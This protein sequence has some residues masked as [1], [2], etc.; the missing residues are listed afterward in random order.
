MDIFNEQALPNNTDNGNQ[1]VIE[2]ISEEYDDSSNPDGPQAE[3]AKLN[4]GNPEEP[5]G[6]PNQPQI[7]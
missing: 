4:E 6:D 1:P 3:E 5:Q 2:D 7:M